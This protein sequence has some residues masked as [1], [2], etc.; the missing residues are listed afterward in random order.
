MLDVK[1]IKEDFPIFKA[2]DKLVYLDNA[3]SSQT[4]KIV[5][6]AMNKYYT[7]FKS[8]IHRGMYD[9]SEIATDKYE[10]ARKTVA[11]FLSANSEEIIF[12]SGA[13]MSAN[14]LAYSLEQSIELNEGDKIVTTVMEHHSSLIP[15]QELA[16][17]NKLSLEFIPVNDSLELDYDVAEELIDKNTK[18]VVVSMASNISGTINNISN[19]ANMA[20]DAGALLVVD[21]SKSVGH[22]SA[23]VKA[24]DCDF[25][26]FSG[27]KMC[28]PTGI[29][30]LYGKSNLLKELHP[31]FYGGGMIEDVS[32]E[33]SMWTSS[34]SRFEAGTPNIAGVIGLAESVEYLDKMGIENI[35]SHIK[36]LTRYAIKELEKLDYVELFCQKNPDK[37]IGVVSFRLKDVHPHDIANILAGDNI[38]ARAGHHCAKLF[39][40]HLDIGGLLRISFYIYNTKED[41]DSLMLS[42]K[43]VKQLFK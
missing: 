29:G 9:M 38:S 5:I 41:V 24:M 23:D 30:V 27:H 25:M 28:G 8:N 22:M 1:K 14:M 26:F 34:P 10:S 7:E 15:F 39:I 37:N 4:P 13:T 6:D 42:L 18:I 21:A 32:N 16:R 36:N 17:R 19:I 11:K 35:H 43:K 31:S 20:H 33:K 2:N 12:T 3:A 40:K